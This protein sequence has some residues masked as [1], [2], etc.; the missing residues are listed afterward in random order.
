MSQFNFSS[1]NG[2]SLDPIDYSSL[3]SYY[4]SPVNTG[5]TSTDVLGKTLN[6]ATGS[7]E[8][9]VNSVSSGALSTPEADSSSWLGEQDWG[10][11]GIGGVGLGLGQLA[12]GFMQWQDQEKT[13]KAQRKLLKQQASN[14]AYEMKRKQ[15]GDANFSKVW[16]TAGINV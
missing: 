3:S 12:L 13:A 9:P 7:W 10:M 5:V 6:P 14:N 2:S 4:T 15:D 11:K 1:V 16:S 8:L